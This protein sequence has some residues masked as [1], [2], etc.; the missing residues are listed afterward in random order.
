MSIQFGKKVSHFREESESIPTELFSW[1][2]EVR[3]DD[4]GAE[5]PERLEDSRSGDQ[6]VPR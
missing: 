6:A 3:R 5:L 4:R 1:R 2:V